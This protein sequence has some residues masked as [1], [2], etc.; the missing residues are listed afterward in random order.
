MAPVTECGRARVELS[1]S[2]GERRD[3]DVFWQ[4]SRRETA[5]HQLKV[6]Q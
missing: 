1:K 3:V 5:V 6:L 2:S 4:E